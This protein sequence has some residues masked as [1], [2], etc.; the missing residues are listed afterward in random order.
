VNHREVAARRQGEQLAM[1]EEAI[2]GREARHLESA[3]AERA[4]MAA[5]ASLEAR[6]KELAA[7]GQSGGAELVNQ[8][9]AAQNTLVDLGRLVQDQAGEIAALRLTNEIGPGQL[10]DAV[11]RLECAGRRVGISVHRARSSRPHSRH[12]RSGWMGWWR[13]WRG[14]RRRSVRP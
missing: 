14:W 4:A 13:I 1:R 10:S 2:A 8:L 12:S 6:E 11:E 7:G 3:H 5:R 9:I